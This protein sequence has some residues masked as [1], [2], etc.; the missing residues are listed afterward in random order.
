MQRE[1]DPTEQRMAQIHRRIAE[2]IRREP[3]V[4]AEAQAR[5]RRVMQREGEE[6]PVLRE[7]LDALLMLDADQLADFI[8]SGT[9]R[10]RRLRSSSPLLWL[11]R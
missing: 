11:A 8:E 1:R 3:S 9:P 5:L 4:L 7:W 6:D 10:A 2:R